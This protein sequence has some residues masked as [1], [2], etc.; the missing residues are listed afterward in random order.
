M[1]NVKILTLDE[2]NEKEE[3]WRTL[4]EMA[5]MLEDVIVAMMGEFDKSEMYNLEVMRMNVNN[6]K[7]IALS[8]WQGLNS[9]VKTKEQ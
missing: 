8:E 1:G 6:A 5:K 9:L 2:A 4:F 3:Q 7:T